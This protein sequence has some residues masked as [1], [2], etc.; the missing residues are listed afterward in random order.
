VPLDPHSSSLNFKEVID[1]N[2][3]AVELNL[4]LTSIR[5]ERSFSG[6]YLLG[7]DQVPT[8]LQRLLTARRRC[9]T[10]SAYTVTAVADCLN[11]VASQRRPWWNGSEHL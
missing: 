10:Y 5:L 4:A 6:T 7:K 3:A 2:V 11:L 1:T 9:L 8:Q